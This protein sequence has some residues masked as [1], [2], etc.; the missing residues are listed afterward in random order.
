MSHCEICHQKISL[1][2]ALPICVSCLRKATEESEQIIQAAHRWRQ[3]L[4]ELPE[5]VPRADD[6]VKCRI[7][8]NECVIPPDGL[9]YC[10]LRKNVSGRLEGRITATKALMHYYFDPHVTNCCGSYFCPGGT[11]I[12]YP[13]WAKKPRAEFGFSNLAVFFYGCSL[14]CLFC[15]NVSHKQISQG[16]SIELEA[17]LKVIEQNEKITCICYF[18]GSPEPQLPFTLQVMEACKT[19]FKN[20]LL[21]QC[22]EMNGHGNSKLMKKMGKY[23]EETGGIIKFDL[24]AY[25]D[26]IYRALCGVSKKPSF[27]NFEMLSDTLSF[28]EKN[29]PPLMATTLLVP[30]YIDED[31]VTQIA[32]FIKELNQPSIEYSLLIFHPCHLMSDLP[33]TPLEQAQRCYD[34]VKQ[35]LGKRPHIGNINLLSGRL[36][37]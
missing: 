1:A 26:S 9:G 14:D 4:F 37:L 2:E 3:Y 34:A 20:R 18:G 16:T 28:D 22:F 15:Q 13:Q 8:A 17:F 19:R 31:E 29:Y 21:R 10:G 23:V 24:K 12:G 27:E 11:G 33:V 35:E 5:D 6:G 7:C 36:H 32:R 25:S 30:H